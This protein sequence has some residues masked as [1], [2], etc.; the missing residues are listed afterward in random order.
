L[1][2]DQTGSQQ[3]VGGHLGRNVACRA[4]ITAV[5]GARS[6]NRRSPRGTHLPS[7]VAGCF[8]L[9]GSATSG[10]AVFAMGLLLAAHPVRL[11]P[12]VFAG[13][14]ARITVQSAIWF[15]LLQLLHV[16]SPFA[17]EALV[18]CSFPLATVVVRFASRY[19]AAR[20]ETASMLLIS[21]LALAITVPAMLWISR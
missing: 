4:E 13:S 15:V 11:S 5:M 6:R 9:I 7:V 12:G 18:C 17:R 3:L 20:S 8:E 2:A 1:G 14:L 21:T 16:V 10:V 19:K